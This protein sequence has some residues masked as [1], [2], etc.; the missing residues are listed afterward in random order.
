MYTIEAARVSVVPR[1][2]LE[3]LLTEANRNET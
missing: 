2:T 3:T 1:M